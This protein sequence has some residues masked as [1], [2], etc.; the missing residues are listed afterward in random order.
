MSENSP[1]IIINRSI[2]RVYRIAE[3]YPCFVDFFMKKDV[4]FSNDQRIAVEVSMRKFGIPFEWAGEGTKQKN[5][6]ID[7]VQTKGLFKGLKAYWFFR[8]V[9]EDS[10]VVTIQTSLPPQTSKFKFLIKKLLSCLLVEGTTRRILE[11]LKN[12][13]ER[14]E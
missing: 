7:F 10:T 9:T 2:E 4:I 11:S 13:C 12:A 14:N 1:K 6:S 5:K 8:A 3:Q